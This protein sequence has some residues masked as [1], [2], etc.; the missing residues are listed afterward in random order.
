MDVRDIS[1][2]LPAVGGV[3]DER[4]LMSQSRNNERFVVISFGRYTGSWTVEL[5][6][7]AGDYCAIPKAYLN[8]GTASKRCTPHCKY[9]RLQ[10]FVIFRAFLWR[11][12]TALTLKIVILPCI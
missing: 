8:Y 11:S 5:T 12:C 1:T 9:Y 3:H 4:L 6:I 7:Q 10:F 2:R